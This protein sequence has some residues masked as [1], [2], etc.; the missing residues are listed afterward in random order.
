MGLNFQ[1][2]KEQSVASAMEIQQELEISSK[3]EVGEDDGWRLYSGGDMEM[4]F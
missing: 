1:G 3:F 4:S 2:S